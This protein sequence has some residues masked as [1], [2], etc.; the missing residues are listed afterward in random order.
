MNFSKNGSP[1]HVSQLCTSLKAAGTGG[2]C[3]AQPVRK[4][5]GQSCFP[6]LPRVWPVHPI[7]CRQWW[8]LE[9]KKKKKGKDPALRISRWPYCGKIY[10]KGKLAFVRDEPSVT[11]CSK[12]RG[13][14]DKASLEKWKLKCFGSES[15][16]ING[17]RGQFV[18]A[19][20]AVIFH[21]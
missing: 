21:V 18:F 11:K 2:W 7:N 1:Q 6:F 5:G 14:E 20:I 3:S 10:H 4:A 17:L 12:N 19:E 15:G 16:F 9:F 8:E 13:N